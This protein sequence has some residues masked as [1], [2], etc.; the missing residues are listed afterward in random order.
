ML[1]F[2]WGS[3]LLF[4]SLIASLA[5]AITLPCIRTSFFDL[6][7]SGIDQI[8]P[9]GGLICQPSGE[10]KLVLGRANHLHHLGQALSICLSGR[11]DSVKPGGDPAQGAVDL[12]HLDCRL[13]GQERC[14]R[15]LLLCPREGCSER[16]QVGRVVLGRLFNQG[17]SH[18][19]LVH[20]GDGG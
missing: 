14:G 4:M 12:L 18:L 7:Q 19:C 13:V 6:P 20:P 15:Q 10:G 11:V 16:E 9:E 1:S 3:S 2:T 5:V 8:E 17:H